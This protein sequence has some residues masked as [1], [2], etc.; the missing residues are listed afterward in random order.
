MWTIPMEP[1]PLTPAWIGWP[2][3][4]ARLRRIEEEAV[5]E[6]AAFRGEALVELLRVAP[7][8][9][10]GHHPG[11]LVRIVEHHP[12]PIVASPWA[13]GVPER[14]VEEDGTACRRAD[15]HRARE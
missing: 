12:C 14:V 3:A 10:R 8:L 9:L 4:P 1:A 6:A 5:K 11:V 7:V 2:L 13:M 15:L